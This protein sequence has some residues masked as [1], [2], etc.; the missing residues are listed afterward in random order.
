MHIEINIDTLLTKIIQE[1]DL[2][3]H[4]QPIVHLQTQQIY[5]YEGLIRGPVNTVLHSPTRLFQAATKTN[6][7]AELDILCRKKVICR[8]AKLSLPG[9]LF[10]NVDPITMLHE[11]F[12][13]GITLQFLQQAGIDPGR[14]IIELTETN[15]VEDIELMQ[16]AVRH[17]RQM[18][19]R[20]ALDDLGAGYSGLKL[21]SEIRP[22]IVKV[23]RHFIQGIDE[24]RT[25]QQFVNAILKTATAL[26][27][28]VITEGVETKK[29][30]ATLRKIGIEMLQ[31]YY[32]CRPVSVP[33]TTLSSKLFRE[34]PRS[35]DTFELLTVE[36]IKRPAVSAQVNT[37]VNHI[38]ELF[39]STPELESVV[40][41]QETE[42]LGM[43]LRKEF[44][45]MYASL[46]GKDLYGKQQIM[47]F[48]NRNVLQVEKY[49]PLENV[50]FRLTT[51]LDLH[52]EEFI[53]LDNCTL[54]GTGRLIDLL[55]EITKLQVNR[56]RHANPLT[57]LP[58]N[59]PIQ[60][61][62]QKLFR[63]NNAFVICYFDLDNFKPF[64]D[65]FGFTR[66]DQ[67]LRFLSELL[68]VN[69]DDQKNFIG[70]IGG[71][72][73][74]CIFETENWQEV[75]Q[76]ILNQFDESISGFYNGNIGCNIR[77]KDRN[78]NTKNFGKMSLSV[79][80][81]LVSS[82][83][84]HCHIDLS[85]EAAIAKKRAKKMKGSSLYIHQLNIGAPSPPVPIYSFAP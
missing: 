54:D 48:I 69:I 16:H 31:G 63:K 52:R 5:G 17:Y 33:P 30:Y 19:F 26:G 65:V 42:V 12:R 21:W 49:M 9:R 51:G 58:G 40:I 22:D 34:E 47:R 84:T 57:L 45:N 77:T 67:V 23:D 35:E 82:S 78:G 10:V 25:K 24:D 71:D 29:E 85:K 1:E 28:R 73:F 36:H 2:S 72:D 41:L 43:V 61:Q 68:V 60:Q 20:V 53:I 50:S 62:L 74:V 76:R 44:M 13:E 18:G 15:P 70:H 46:Y 75:I 64:N 6:Q 8:F 79:G 7:L 55:H 38:G 80:A 56:A 66:G 3:V 32:F 81:V 11:Q 39:T 4:F 14:I 83:N 37:S 59:V 27:S